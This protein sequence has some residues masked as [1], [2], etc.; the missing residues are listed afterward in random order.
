MLV[1]GL[2]VLGIPRQSV[3]FWEITVQ[4][5]CDLRLSVPDWS[6]NMSNPAGKCQ[7]RFVEDVFVPCWVMPGPQISLQCITLMFS[8]F[9]YYTGLSKL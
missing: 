5:T 1:F 3:P 2:L 8:A 7:D 4:C 6:L 9:H